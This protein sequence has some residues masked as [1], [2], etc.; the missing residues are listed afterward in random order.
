MKVK[1]VDD[2]QQL[3]DIPNIG[4]ETEKDLN[5]IGIYTPDDLKGKD[6]FEMY[7]KL[8]E[9]S[10]K[11]HDPCTA[12]IFLSAV[13]YMKSGNALPWWKYTKFRKSEMKKRG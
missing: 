11:I 10:K 12:D 13:D 4:K 3:T 9:V 7:F 5:L 6:P 2:V 8:N 1:K